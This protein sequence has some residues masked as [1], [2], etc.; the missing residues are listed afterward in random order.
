[1]ARINPSHATKQLLSGYCGII[2]GALGIH[3]FV[4]GYTQEGVIMLVVSIIGVYFAYGLPLIIMQLVGLI[5][6]MIYLNKNHD[7]FVNTYFMNKQG[8]F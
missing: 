3:K 4:L 6:G 7:E 5:E 1:M 2:F 8:W